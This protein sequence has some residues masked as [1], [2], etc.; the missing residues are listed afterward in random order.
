MSACRTNKDKAVITGNIIDPTPAKIEYTIPINGISYFGFKESVQP[1]S[2]GNFRIIIDVE[3]SAIVEFLKDFKS[4]GAIIIEPGMNYN[5]TINTELKEDAFKI[6][7]KNQAGQELYSRLKNRSIAGGHFELEARDFYKNSDTNNIKL[8]LINRKD[9]EITGFRDLLEKKFISQDFFDIVKSD[10]EFFYTGA[11]GSVA[12][13]NYLSEP[14]G[15][16]SLNEAQYKDLWKGVFKS[17]PVSDP[18]LLSSPWFY[19]YVQNYLRYRELIVDSTDVE[20]ISDFHKAGLIHTHYIQTAKK[21]L[22]DPS[23]EYY[24]AAYI[25]YEA[26]NRNYEKELVSLL[27]QFKEDYP[28]SKYTKYLNPLADEIVEFHKKAEQEYS[29]KSEFLANYESLN[30]LKDCLKSFNGRKVYIDTWATWCGPCKDEFKHKTELSAL[31][32]SKNTDILYIS[33]DKDADAQKWK[34]MIKFYRLEGY[35][36]RA[37]QELTNDLRKIFGQNGSLSIPWY[38]LVDEMGNIISEH[39]KP[40]SKISE[41]EKQINEI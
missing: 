33:I 8:S 6:T 18:G 1:D 30:S 4:Y 36:V 24:N 32:K 19:Y 40:P 31:L 16:N 14:T 10:R 26:I 7:C 12:F 15:R 13:I 3:K 38:I 5:I 21:Y 41:L 25:Y 11:L 35:H 23:L 29:D 37:N 28:D 34:D 9:N 17:K 2:L 27:T 20:T 39:A 22:S